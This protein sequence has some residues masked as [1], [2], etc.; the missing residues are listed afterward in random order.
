MLKGFGAS[1]AMEVI[2]TGIGFMAVDFGCQV[3]FGGGRAKGS[4][5]GV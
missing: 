2:G 3:P 5:L 1:F 4:G